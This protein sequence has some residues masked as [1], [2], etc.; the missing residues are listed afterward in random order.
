MPPVE[1]VGGLRVL[2]PAMAVVTAHEQLPAGSRAE[3]VYSPVRQGIVT[4]DML[5][6]ALQGGYRIR[7]RPELIRR[8]ASAGTGA[9][10]FL[11]E[12]GAARVLT[13]REFSRIIRQHVVTVQRQLYRLDALDPLLLLN[14]EFDGARTHGTPEGRRKDAV[15]DLLLASIGMLTVRFTFREVMD[16]PEWC[17]DR[18]L[19]V[20][21][22]RA[23]QLGVSSTVTDC[24]GPGGSSRS[25]SLVVPN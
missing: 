8:I 2:D 21:R 24:P 25:P 5:S 1:M 3:A 11:E 15:R 12:E 13:G 6:A 22:T 7:A 4:A 17:R 19:E 14:L 9:E 10:S 16:R 23:D 18:V 20:M